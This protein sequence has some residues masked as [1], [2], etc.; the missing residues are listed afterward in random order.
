[1]GDVLAGDPDR[2]AIHGCSTV[3]TPAGAGW[4]A[5]LGLVAREAVVLRST[6]AT[7]DD[8]PCANA[9]DP[10]ERGEGRAWVQAVAGRRERHHAPAA[11]RHADGRIGE[12]VTGRAEIALQRDLVGVGI[13]D[14]PGDP[15]TLRAAIG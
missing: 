1:M 2:V 11:G 6:L 3:V 7:G 4:V 12:I 14:V 10:V 5:D 9:S 15:G 13:D 8:A